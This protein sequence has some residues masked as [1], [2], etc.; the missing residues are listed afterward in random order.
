[1]SVQLEDDEARLALTA[2]AEARQRISETMIEA[3]QEGK[4]IQASWV[5]LRDSYMAVE[6]TIR[7]QLSGPGNDRRA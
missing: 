2:L 5:A 3:R 7:S 6:S 4:Q 1:M